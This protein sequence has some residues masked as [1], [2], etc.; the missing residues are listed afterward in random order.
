[1]FFAIEGTGRKGNIQVRPNS[2]FA[3]GV[4]LLHH[5]TSSVLVYIPDTKQTPPDTTQTPPVWE[6]YAV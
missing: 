3:N 2:N 4:V 6:F 1:M 5:E